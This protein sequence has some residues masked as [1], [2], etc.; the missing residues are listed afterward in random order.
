MGKVNG[1]LEE[2]RR[3]KAYSKIMN[4]ASTQV[5]EQ[6][7]YRSTMADIFSDTNGFSAKTLNA[8]NKEMLYKDDKKD[9]KNYGWRKDMDQY[10]TE[11]KKTVRES[12]KATRDVA[13]SYK[14]TDSKIR[15]YDR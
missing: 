4:Q 2:E 13:G 6:D 5:Q 7:A 3:T 9:S 12:T 11:Y 1:M 8:I 15:D 10:E 14:S